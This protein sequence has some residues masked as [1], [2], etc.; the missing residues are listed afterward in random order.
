MSRRGEI[1]DYLLGELPPGRAQEVARRCEQDPAAAAE[2]DRCL[3]TLGLLREAAEEG[4]EAEPAARPGLLRRL[5]RSVLAAAAL[6]AAVV[7]LFLL[8]GRGLQAVYEPDQ[9]LGYLRPE[10]T[11]SAGR[12][13]VPARGEGFTLRSRAATL[14][15]R[16]TDRQFALGRNDEIAADSEVTAPSGEGVRLDLPGGGILFLAPGST[17]LLRLRDDGS[18]ALRLGDG[19]AAAVAGDRPVHLAVD[20]TDLLLDLQ[21]GAC[22]LNRNPGEAA[23]LRGSLFL[24]RAKG[25]RF[26]IPEAERLPAACASEP[27]TVA[28]VESDLDL[29]WYRDLV[30]RDYRWRDLTW[31]EAGPGR[32]VAA[33]RPGDEVLFLRLVPAENGTIEV[34]RGGPPRAFRVRE[35]KPLR[36]RLRLRDLG[37]GPDLELRCAGPFP[38]LREARLFSA[39]PR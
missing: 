22:Y 10:E 12:V 9:A 31:T 20:G 15:P 35:G 30:Y 3:R 25:G 13:P 11:D 21:S 38:A 7:S 14:S 16:G 6:L 29:D 24:D 26:H 5:S 37:P 28:L 33:T 8:N 2:R 36:L 34:A 17:V 19:A 32:H 1:L 27:K 4:W 18:P 39:T 23:C